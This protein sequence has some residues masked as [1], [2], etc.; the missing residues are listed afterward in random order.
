MSKNE[1]PWLIEGRELDIGRGIEAALFGLFMLALRML[2]TA[3]AFIA[4]WRSIEEVIFSDDTPKDAARQFIRPLTFV[5]ITW[6][7]YLVTFSDKFLLAQKMFPDF[8]KHI[9]YFFGPSISKA[10]ITYLVSFTSLANFVSTH[11]ASGN[12]WS[13]TL[14]SVPV[15]ATIGILTASTTLSCRLSGAV[16]KPREHLAIT[17]YF[18]GVIP[19]VDYAYLVCEYVAGLIYDKAY[20]FSHLFFYIVVWPRLV[21]YWLRLIKISSH[22]RG[23]SFSLLIIIDLAIILAFSVIVAVSI[24]CLWEWSPP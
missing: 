5:V 8:A 23:K 24:S 10:F 21:L 16:A 20:I 19:V 6:L 11:A 13:L 2:R 17:C 1:S 12:L 7:L 3:W 14:A 15:L 9:E 18:L 4:R 22:T